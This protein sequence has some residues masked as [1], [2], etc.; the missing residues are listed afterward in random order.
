MGGMARGGINRDVTLFL[1]D[2]QC[3]LGNP[4]IP[5]GKDTLSQFAMYNSKVASIGRKG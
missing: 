5:V 1:V 2:R 3:R 4:S